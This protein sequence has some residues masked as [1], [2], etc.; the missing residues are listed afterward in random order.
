MQKITIDG[1]EYNLSEFTDAAKAQLIHL[2]AAEMEIH[3]MNLHLAIYQTARAAYLESLKSELER[4][5]SDTSGVGS[6]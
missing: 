2:Q 6:A 1:K 4:P 3:R 5:R